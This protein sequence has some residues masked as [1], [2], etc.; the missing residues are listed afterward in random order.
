MD[1]YEKLDVEERWLARGATVLRLPMTFGPRDGQRREE[2]ILRRVRAGRTRIPVG[3]ANG[4][5]THG[6]VA[7]VALGVRLVIDADAA[8][9]EGEVFNLGEQRT[10]PVGL[11]ARWILEAAGKADEVEL[12]RVPDAALPPDLG[13]TGAI[14]Q[15]LLVQSDKARTVLGWTTTDPLE[16][17]RVSVEWHMESPPQ[18]SDPGFGA[19]DAAL[20]EAV[21]VEPDSGA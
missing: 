7:D 8:A 16:A 13:L 4:L 11:R 19:D 15:H 17:L 14:A 10:P 12:V 21:A 5:L 3:A 1:D 2:F 9:V 20:A 18:T 6:Y